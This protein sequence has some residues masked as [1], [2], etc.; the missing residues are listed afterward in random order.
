MGRGGSMEGGVAGE[1][2]ETPSVGVGCRDSGGCGGGA[3]GAGRNGGSEGAADG[4]AEGYKRYKGERVN[5]KKL[6]TDYEEALN[7]L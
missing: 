4:E 1:G 2:G 7:R 5:T 3:G 6:L